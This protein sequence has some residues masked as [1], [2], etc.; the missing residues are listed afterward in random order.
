MCHIN[1]AVALDCC[2]SKSFSSDMLT[3]FATRICLVEVKL[4]CMTFFVQI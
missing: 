3:R 2:G 4:A 1:S